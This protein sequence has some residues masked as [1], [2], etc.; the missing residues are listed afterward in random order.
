MLGYTLPYYNRL[1]PADNK[2]Y[3][4]YYCE[5]CHQLRAGFGLRSTLT[6]NYDMTFNT[7]LLNSIAGDVLDFEGT[8][9]KICV[10]DRPK[11]DSD[12]MR[13]MAAYTL[14]LTKWEL[15]DDDTDKPS[16]KSKAASVT[17]RNAMDKAVGMY[18]E[19]DRMVGEGFS[20]LH[21]LEL[22]G[23]K[24]AVKMGRTFGEGLI[25]ALRDMAGE[26]ASEDLDNV[27]RQLS[28]VVYLMDAIDDLDEDFLDG[29]YNPLLPEKGFTNSADFRMKNVYDLSGMLN[30]EIGALQ[31]SYSRVRSLMRSGTGI[32]DNIVYYGIPDSAKRVMMGSSTAKTSVKNVLSN[33]KQRMSEGT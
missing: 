23:C 8:K 20:R 4:R 32:C 6:V 18:P 5:G 15:R 33:R 26:H 17:L 2:L 7:I 9:K 31:E 12:L 14:I 30:G 3:R 10:L 13:S 29:T 22:E 11:A 24:D 1:S 19:Y 16:L 25:G 28:T 21:E 27:F